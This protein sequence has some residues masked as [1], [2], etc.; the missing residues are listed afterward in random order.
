MIGWGGYRGF[1][2]KPPDWMAAEDLLSNYL[3][4]WL[5]RVYYLY[6]WL[7]HRIFFHF[8]VF[9]WEE[10]HMPQSVHVWRSENDL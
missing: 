10:L 6:N 8:Y 1:H 2:N 7:P 4:G 9:I 3:I 5:Q